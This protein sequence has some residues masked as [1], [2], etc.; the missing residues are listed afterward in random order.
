MLDYIIRG[1]WAL[2]VI[3]L[4]SIISLG[5]TFERW[6]I[7]RK[8]NV[9]SED[10]LDDVSAALDKGR[11]D[12]AIE[13]CSRTGGPVAE[14]LAIGLRKLVFLE[15][16]GK[17]PEEIEQGIVEAME[18]HGGHVVEFLERNLTVLATVASLAPILGMLG[19]VFG[20]I[21]AFGSI[22]QAQVLTP[23]VVSTGI[24]EALHCTA[25][26]LV[27]AAMATVEFNYFTT[28]VNRFV[29]KVQAAGTALVE[30][31]LNAQSRA[32]GNGHD[33][34]AVQAATV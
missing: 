4:C 25:G 16:I 34:G 20:M 18:D 7:L 11:L 27:V 24:S 1:G 17:R 3:T 33:A 29:L 28:R 6:L 8:A 10:L 15:G 13:R 31:V 23:E 32:R 9:D 26:G 21:R 12:G 5:V 30:R 19:T 2:W 22:G 14:T